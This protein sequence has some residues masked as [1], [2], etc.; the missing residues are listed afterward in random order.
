MA[1]WLETWLSHKAGEVRVSTLEGYRQIVQNH[2]LPTLG[3]ERLDRLQP[4]HVDGLHKT[5]QAKGLSHRMV[6]YAH[7]LLHGALDYAVRLERLPRNVAALVKLPRKLESKERLYWSIEEGT[8]FLQHLERTNHRLYAFFYTAL[9][10]GMRRGELCGLRWSDLNPEGGSLR[11]GNAV[12]EVKGGKQ[13]AEP[14]TPASKRTVVLSSKTVKVLEAQKARLEQEKEVLAGHP[15]LDKWI[16]EDLV[17]PNARGRAL[18]SSTLSHTF[19]KL[20]GE[21]GVRP[22]R[23]HDLRHTHASLLAFHGVPAKVI[24]DR[25]GHTNVGFTLRVY[26][27][28]YDA[29]R[30]EGALELFGSSAC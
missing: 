20:C 13:F 28:L 9:S 5:L 2:L 23:I 14:K 17:F 27:H 25:L 29:Q 15:K 16:E 26:T 3:G 12:I 4:R 24:S 1:C 8:R 11:V 21:A 30:K 6:E 22:I 18:D 19:R 10:T 7:V